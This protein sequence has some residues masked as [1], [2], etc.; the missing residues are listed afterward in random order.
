[1]ERERFEELI[2]DYIE[3]NLSRQEEDEFLSAMT[4]HHEY[5][6]I[7]DHYL[8]IRNIMESEEEIAP[9]PEILKNISDYAKE[10]FRKENPSVFKQWF[11]M[12]ILA[13]VL[14]VAIVAFFWFSIGEEYLREKNIIR[15]AEINQDDSL[16][17]SESGRTEPYPATEPLITD[18]QILDVETYKPGSEVNEKLDV[19]ASSPTSPEFDIGGKSETSPDTRSNLQPE[20]EE[21]LAEKGSVGS[22]ESRTVLGF[23]DVQKK[24]ESKSDIKDLPETDKEIQYAEKTRDEDK[25]L[26]K[27]GTAAKVAVIK[28]KNGSISAD[29]PGG[30]EYFRQKMNDVL[31]QQYQG[32]CVNSIKTSNEVLN[33]KPEPPKAVKTTLYLSQAECYEELNQI[34]D[35]IE[36]Y[37][38]VQTIDPSSNSFFSS[39]IR[40]LNMKKAK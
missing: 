4:E 37:E 21:L 17:N 7:Y 38:K 36:A 13:P 18:E 11:T 2:I 32:D 39:K 5:R 23:A 12:P 24:N 31:L 3:G 33:S 25:S 9:R 20:Q 26:K 19:L 1:M 15:V 29:Q 8:S 35:A 30:V 28:P 40:Q 34:D 27:E 16:T 22:A 14:G 6:E 10:S